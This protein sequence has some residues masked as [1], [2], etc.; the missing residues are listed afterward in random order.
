MASCSL[1]LKASSHSSFCTLDIPRRIPSRDTHAFADKRVTQLAPHA[2]T[3]EQCFAPARLPVCVCVH[4]HTLMYTAYSDERHCSLVR[5]LRI[6]CL[7]LPAHTRS[8]FLYLQECVCVLV[9]LW[10]DLMHT[11]P[12]VPDCDL[13]STHTDVQGSQVECVRHNNSVLTAA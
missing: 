6:S 13:P 3:V 7:L 5:V 9:S 8:K 11:A 2:V 1:Q 12:I 4:T 10:H